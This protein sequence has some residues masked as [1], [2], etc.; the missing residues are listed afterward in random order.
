MEKIIIQNN[1]ALF[2]YVGESLDLMKVPDSSNNELY[3]L[4]NNLINNTLAIY[5]TSR[6]DGSIPVFW[7]KLENNE[8]LSRSPD[9]SSTLRKL[10]NGKSYYILVDNSSSFPLIIPTPVNFDKLSVCDCTDSSQDISCCEQISVSGQ[11]SNIELSGTYI[12][13]ISIGLS[14]LKPNLKYYYE[15]EPILSNWP[16]KIYPLSGFIERNA[17]S[18][19]KNSIKANLELTFSYISLN[20]S[21]NINNNLNNQDTKNI[22][23]VIDMSI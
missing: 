13:N 19:K 22:Y 7:T 10:D 3:S 5:S 6:S 20:D 18:D 12:K 2:T 8:R 23:S 1:K 16:A 11:Y 21:G 17:P 14:G 15:L 4:Y 9:Q